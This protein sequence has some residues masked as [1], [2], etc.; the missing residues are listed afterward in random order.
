MYTSLIKTMYKTSSSASLG[1]SEGVHHSGWRC[2]G[3]SKK[4]LWPWLCH[5]HPRST[6]RL[7][8][9]LSSASSAPPAHSACQSLK[10]NNQYKHDQGTIN[11]KLQ[12]DSRLYY[13]PPM[14]CLHF[15]LFFSGIF[16]KENKIHIWL[17]GLHNSI[18]ICLAGRLEV[19][20]SFQW[21]HLCTK[22]KLC[23]HMST[24]LKI[25]FKKEERNWYTSTLS[26][27]SPFW[28]QYGDM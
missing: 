7:C 19:C 2:P 25:N 12:P 1:S 3:C 20:Y 26:R 18:V 10:W 22:W 9:S 4:R 8:H 11:Y 28:K 24:I 5:G 21:H 17:N 15:N 13:V 6:S 16:L 27:Q 23:I 14:K